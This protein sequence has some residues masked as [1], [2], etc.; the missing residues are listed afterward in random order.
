MAAS[1]HR[2]NLS[3]KSRMLS[4]RH[5]G[6]GHAP[7][8]QITRQWLHRSRSR[9]ALHALICP[10]QFPTFLK[11]GKCS[12]HVAQLMTEMFATHCNVWPLR[13]VAQPRGQCCAS[14]C[15]LKTVGIMR[16][17]GMPHWQS[18]HLYMMSRTQRCMCAK[19]ITAKLISACI[20][21]M[22]APARCNNTSMPCRQC[23]CP[24][25]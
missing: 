18:A 21:L 11:S 3:R 19:L 24:E 13:R 1:L 8:L 16:H 12:H 15:H 25:V 17:G 4:E 10:C 20:W 7:S 9:A 14:G 5:A 2:P 23:S 22:M 6:G